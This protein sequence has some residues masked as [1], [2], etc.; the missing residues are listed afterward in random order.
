MNIKLAI[1]DHNTAEVSQREIFA[2]TK[3]AQEIA[4]E[5]IKKLKN[6]SGCVILSTCNRTELYISAKD[7]EEPPCPFTVLCDLKRL[8]SALYSKC[9]TV[10]QGADVA[11]H[12]FELACGMKSQI[13]GE[14]QIIT[15]VKDA[16]NLA[17]EMD[18]LSPKL[19]LLFKSA[20]TTAKKVKSNVR[21][22]LNESSL[23]DTT[24]S[25][26]RK[27]FQNLSEVTAL[28]IGNGKMGKIVARELIASGVSVIMTL[29]NYKRG[30]VEIPNGCKVIEY[31]KRFEYISDVDV[32]VSATRSPHHTV[33]L[34]DVKDKISG[35]TVFVDLAMP[36]D[37]ESEIQ[38][39]EG[40]K[41]YNIDS[42]K[43]HGTS[44]S[45]ETA[46]TI[47]AD[48][49]HKMLTTHRFKNHITAVNEITGSTARYVSKRVKDKTR[50]IDLS[51]YIEEITSNAVAKLLYG[52]RDN[53][54]YTQWENVLIALEKG[55]KK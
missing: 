17:D 32:V 21:L 29:R 51:N 37:I 41:L 13:Y 47:I 15:Q 26:I 3:S 27:E 28:L 43:T 46:L 8:D 31:E 30:Y 6:V 48:D 55:A 1:I 7:G 50:D 44:E 16:Y 38:N 39:I 2:F 11:Y 10:I 49:I 23:G 42:F 22:A 35:K 5:K 18:S 40:V 20:I 24:L 45:T 54:D 9:A 33:C 36:R 25:L 34:S 53:L 4:I 12:L 19:N 14:D 52:M